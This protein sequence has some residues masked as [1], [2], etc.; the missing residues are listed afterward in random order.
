MRRWV[1]GRRSDIQADDARPA[2][3][4]PSGC[5]PL[6]VTVAAG[7]SSSQ[8]A[9]NSGSATHAVAAGCG[10]TAIHRGTPPDWTAP[11]WAAS[12]GAPTGLPYAV[13]EQGDAIAFI[14]GY[15]L[16]AGNPT[17]PNNKI[18]W[19]VRSPRDGS[20]LVIR[21]RPLHATTPIITV[22]QA[23]N[24]GPGEIYP[25]DVNV[26]VR[27]LLADDAALERARRLRR[28][29]L[30]RCKA[31]V[32]AARLSARLT[33]GGR[34]L[35]ARPNHVHDAIMS[36]GTGDSGTERRADRRAQRLGH[37]WMSRGCIDCGHHKPL[38]TAYCDRCAELH[39]LP[40]AS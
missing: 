9:S 15:P 8:P 3:S 38:F 33:P 20:D 37:G 2:T 17:N 24:S 40:A 26:P 31:G 35:A 19:V 12:S 23:A 1:S 34:R 13:A 6:V 28:S 32:A 4:C 22:R 36:T 5:C 10:A 39:G 30:P 7:C 18:L 16:R 14:F 11:A 27:W 29:R 25:S 21:A